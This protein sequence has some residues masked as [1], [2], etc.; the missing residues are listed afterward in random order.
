MRRN[1]DVLDQVGGPNIHCHP[2]LSD[3]SPM[4]SEYPFI[5]IVSG[6]DRC[7]IAS[8][9]EVKKQI[10]PKLK[11]FVHMRCPNGP[12]YKNHDSRSG[13]GA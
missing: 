10:P 11:I 7:I 8:V 1:G 13:R 12:V 3:S 6:R 5:S 4:P 2:F 9:F